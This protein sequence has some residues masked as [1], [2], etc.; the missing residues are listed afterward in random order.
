MSETFTYN[1]AI[2]QSDTITTSGTYDLVAY[3]AQGGAGAGTTGGNGAEIGGQFVLT[4]GEVIEIIVGGTGTD[5][6]DGGGGGGGTFVI[7]TFDGANPVHVPLVVGGGGGGGAFTD[8]NGAGGSISTSGGDG[9]GSGGTGGTSGGGGDGDGGG[10]GGGGGG[11]YNGG[12]GGSYSGSGTNGSGNN[13][14]SYNGGGSYG[15]GDGGFGGGGGGFNGGGGGGGY[16]G[17]GGGYGANGDGSGSGDG[18]GGG[19][20]SF[21][22]GT[23]QVLVAGENTGDGMVTINMV[24]FLRGT[25]LATPEGETVV[26]ALSIGD[27]VATRLNGATVFKPIKWVGWRRID[28]RA[29][30]DLEAIAPVL[31]EREAFADNVPHR[32]LLARIMH[33]GRRA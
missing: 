27:M 26:E 28:P 4:S 33:G 24:C 13:G 31:I 11:G 3:G 17:G 5:S 8:S 21:D 25:R 22:A 1:G 7:E 6:Y 23:N 2:I 14:S 10:I 20:G 18:G 12:T 9:A 30:L 19:G 32:N 15:G 29:Y 16:S